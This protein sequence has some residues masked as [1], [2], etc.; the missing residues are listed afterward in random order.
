MD[1]ISWC[2]SNIESNVFKEVIN[3]AGPEYTHNILLLGDYGDAAIELFRSHQ[4]IYSVFLVT[5]SALTLVTQELKIAAF[6]SNRKEAYFEGN[7][8]D[9]VCVIK[10]DLKGFH[11]WKKNLDLIF[12]GLIYE[13]SWLKMFQNIKLNDLEKTCQNTFSNSNLFKKYPFQYLLQH[14]LKNPLWKSIFQTFNKHLSKNPLSQS[15]FKAFNKQ[16][17]IKSNLNN[18]S[19]NDQEKNPYSSLF[20]NGKYDP[21]N[22]PNFFDIPHEQIQ[23]EKINLINQDFVKYLTETNKQFSF[24]SCGN[25]LDLYNV[26]EI[27]AILKLLNGVLWEKG[28]IL[29][30]SISSDY[31]LRELINKYFLILDIGRP[32]LD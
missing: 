4:N 20:L 3:T 13:D 9:L 31:P 21:E 19:K 25:L 1:V 28:R 18:E 5:S 32:Y 22:Y 29:F 10:K 17:V 6:K 26:D 7:K 23:T 14:N 2:D 24:I 15:L 27:K 30:R 12:S 16:Y 11:Y 8:L